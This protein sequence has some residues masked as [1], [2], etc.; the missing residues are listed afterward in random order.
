MFMAQPEVTTTTVSPEINPT[1]EKER[2]NRRREGKVFSHLVDKAAFVD[3]ITLSVDSD[4]KPQLDEIVD[5]KNEGIR[6]KHSNY[7]RMVTGR[8]KVTGN[9]VTILYG[10]VN[11]FS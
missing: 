3:T 5:Q 2:R 7:A 6:S 1:V 8:W 9:P 10:K 4:Q 11:R